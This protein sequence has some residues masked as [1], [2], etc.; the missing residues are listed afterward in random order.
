VTAEQ[1]MLPDARE[2][3]TVRSKLPPVEQWELACADNPHLKRAVVDCAV[4]LAEQGR[5]VTVAVL[6]EELRS[7]IHTVGDVYQLNNTWRR[8]AA[9]WLVS[10]RPEFASS[11]KLRK[12]GR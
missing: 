8:P 7:R 5:R 4:Q 12:A 9:E 1:L 11:I 3:A 2:V 10:V 6:W